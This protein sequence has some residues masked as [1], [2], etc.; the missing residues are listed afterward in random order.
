MEF[1][2]CICSAASL[3]IEQLVNLELKMKSNDNSVTTDVK[4]L[5]DNIKKYPKKDR[6]II[7]S[8][9]KKYLD[10]NVSINGSFAESNYEEKKVN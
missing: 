5:I 9:V 4:D 2:P 8:Y 3:A 10:M 7:L 1:L 6:A